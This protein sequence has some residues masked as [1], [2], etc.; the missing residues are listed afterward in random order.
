MNW[1]TRLKVEQSLVGARLRWRA[2]QPVPHIPQVCLLRGIQDA[3]DFSELCSVLAG[4]GT[5][6]PRQVSCMS[7]PDQGEMACAHADAT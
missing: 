3:L 1:E 2:L 4:G 7:R 6:N 5:L